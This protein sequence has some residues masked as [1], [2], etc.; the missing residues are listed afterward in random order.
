M[1]Y[2]CLN[3]FLYFGILFV[4]EYQLIQAFMAKISKFEH[5]QSD[6]VDDSVKIEKKLV[7]RNVSTLIDRKF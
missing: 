3:P 2:L 5:S 4:A 6:E 1:V 7:A